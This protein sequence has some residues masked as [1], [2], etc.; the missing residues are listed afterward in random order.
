MADPIW[1]RLRLK[2]ERG[3]D[4]MNHLLQVLPHIGHYLQ[5]SDGLYRVTGVI[6][7]R[8][9]S[10]PICIQAVWEGTEMVL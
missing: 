9:A 6:H 7:P 2:N 3:V 10:L 8:S 5:L 4:E 1:V